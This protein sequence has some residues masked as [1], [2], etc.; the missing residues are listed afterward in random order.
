MEGIALRPFYEYRL[1]KGMKMNKNKKTQNKEK[2]K[3]YGLFAAAF[4][5]AAGV[6]AVM[7]YM[8]KQALSDYEKIDIY[9]ALTSIPRGVVIDET[10]AGKYMELKSVDAG[11]IPDGAVTDEKKL[12]GLSPV[13]GISEG[14]LLTDSMFIARDDILNTMEEPVLAGFRADDLSRAVSGV[15]RAGDVID[16]YSA[17]PD[18]GKGI[19]LCKNAYVEKGYDSSGNEAMGDAAAVMFNIYLE[20]SE[21]ERFYE[22]IKNGSIYVVRRCG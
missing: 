20:Y 11:C 13:Y 16:I 22:G 7:T 5:V 1:L 17:E 14:T 3:G 18:T 19:L 12:E 21:V 8:Q 4:V 6:F 9:V 15:L 2:G 10:N